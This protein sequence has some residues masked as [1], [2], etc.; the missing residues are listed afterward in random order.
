MID[1]RK[2]LGMLG[3][4][5]KAGKITFGAE[6]CKDS[7]MRNKV[8]LVLLARDASDRTKTKFKD[9]AS[10]KKIPVF[11]VSSIDEISKAIGKKNKAIVG[12][13]DFNF[14]KAIIKII[15]GGGEF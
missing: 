13:L 1:E 12:I 11:E 6:S 2:L 3:I 4:A 10:S 14:S 5:T 7:I 15:N 9:L 8:K